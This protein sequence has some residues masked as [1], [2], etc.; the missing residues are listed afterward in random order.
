MA[1]GISCVP[2]LTMSLAQLDWTLIPVA[3]PRAR[4]DLARDLTTEF[5][6]HAIRI[7][8]NRKIKLVSLQP[9]MSTR[10]LGSNPQ[11]GRLQGP[12]TGDWEISEVLAKRST[13]QYLGTL[14]LKGAA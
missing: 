2:F 5:A 13:P 14:A 1:L 6:G 8:V 10:S 4:Q 3:E 12:S 11:F 9:R 7:N